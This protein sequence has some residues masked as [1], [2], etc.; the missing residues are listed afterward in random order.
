MGVTRT[1]PAA[2]PTSGR[3]TARIHTTSDRKGGSSDGA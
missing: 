3:G 2:P 1:A